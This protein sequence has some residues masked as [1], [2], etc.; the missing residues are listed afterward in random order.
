MTNWKEIHPDFTERLVEKWTAKGFTYEQVKN[1]VNVQGDKFDVNNYSGY[2]EEQE[3]ESQWKSNE[4][5]EVI[6]SEVDLTT[7]SQD[8]PKS[9]LTK[10]IPKSEEI[11]RVWSSKE[12]DLSE[13]SLVLKESRKE[14]KTP[15]EEF[16]KE[17]TQEWIELGF[18]KEKYEEWLDIGLKVEDNSYCTWL[19]EQYREYLK[20]QNKTKNLAQE[21]L[22]KM[23]PKEERRWV[24][25][26]YLSETSLEGELD[27]GNFTYEWLKVYISSYLD[28]NKLEIKGKNKWIEITKLVQA[29]EYMNQ[30][31]PVKEK[32]KE[33]TELNI[34]GQKL[35]GDLDLSDF[36]ELREL[37][38]FDNKLT[39]LNLSNCLQLEKITCSYNRLTN[40][41]VI[42][43]LNLTLLSCENNLLNNVTLPINSIN[44]KKLNLRDNNF[45][46]QDLSFLVPYINLEELRLGNDYWYKREINRSIYN[47]FTGSLDYLSSMKQLKI[48][49]ISDTDISEVNIDKLPKSLEKINYEIEERPTCKLNKIVPQLEEY[50]WKDLHPGFNIEFQK[51]WKKEKFDKE[52]T[53]SWVKLGFEPNYYPNFEKW[54]E[55][56][57]TFEQLKEWLIVAG[58]EPNDYN[59]VSYL[60]DIKRITP[61]EFLDNKEQEDYQK[62]RVK[63]NKYGWCQKC[64]Q[65]NTSKNWCQFCEEQEWQRD[66]KNL[67]GQE[68]IEKFIQQQLK[69]T[70]KNK[71]LNWIPYEQF[72]DVEY[73]AEGGFSKVYK[74]RW[75]KKLI[76]YWSDKNNKWEK[77]PREI[78]LK[79]LNDSQLITLDFL[80]E[81]ANNKLIDNDYFCLAVKCYGISQNPD[82]KNYLIVMEYIPGNN[83]R[84]FLQNKFR[85]LSWKD[86]IS[87]LN[88]I[89]CGL[90]LIHEQ[91]LV[92]KD[93]HPGN[94]LNKNLINSYITDLGLSRP[95]SH[96]KEE[97]KIFGVLPYVAPEVLRG[98]PYTQASDIYS[99]GMV[100]YEILTGLPP[101]AVYDE[102]EKIYKETPY[103][104]NLATKIC[105]GLRPQFQIR[106]PNSLEILVR[107]CWEE[108]LTQRP[109]TKELCDT[110]YWYINKIKDKK[111]EFTHKVQEVEEYNKNLSEN[112]RLPRLEKHIKT[113]YYSKP[114]D[115]KQITELVKKHQKTEQTSSQ[116]TKITE[117][118]KEIEKKLEELKNPLD[119]ELSTLVGKF[120]EAKKKLIKDKKNKEAKIEARKLGKQLEERGL[121]E[122]KIEGIIRYCENLVE[123]EKQLEQEQL[124][125]NIEIPPKK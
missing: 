122:E 75:T 108:D 76:N 59:F 6:F 120:A 112:I 84:Q 118:I 25:E 33:V 61:Q 4:I 50:E 37:Y 56:N 71:T 43:C 35:E 58:T 39:S 102:K 2:A 74:A 104:I 114:I 14:Q 53:R 86:K 91:G 90:N 52:Q 26:I 47:K 27:L 8:Q 18:S 101:Y 9:E 95:V 29:Q 117:Q 107:R 79:S 23:Y 125:T 78:V 45:S 34:N 77:N 49:D 62:L 21:W 88:C 69:K 82:T 30:Q 15:F 24:E 19:R 12:V 20:K 106:I 119:N 73:L 31:Y 89:S 63:C 38:S 85:E 111:T 17:I 98:Q 44:L 123:L 109:N 28:E 66:I 42:N 13:K 55:K 46:V 10:E 1:L 93:L 96:Q 57:F 70:D 113:V 32:R 124:Q 83:L 121:V 51:S 7:N 16:T 22:D 54:K 94:I 80:K 5:K 87:K 116:L 97:G 64:H 41:D 115:T 68:V 65:F 100:A 36:F 103:N 99:F 72:K 11:T 110:L 40:L 3:T 67:T 48:L 81:T 92:H 60:R 105:W